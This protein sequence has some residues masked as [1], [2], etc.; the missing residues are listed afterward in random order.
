MHHALDVPRSA[1]ADRPFGKLGER[2]RFRNQ[3]VDQFPS[4]R[5]G[6]SPESAQRDPIGGIGF[7]KLLHCLP[8]R[9]HFLADLAKRKSESFANGRDPSHSPGAGEASA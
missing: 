8:A 3:C 9:T 2:A 1:V 4:H 7:F 6:S 5:F